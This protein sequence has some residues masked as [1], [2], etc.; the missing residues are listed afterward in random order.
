[1]TLDDDERRRR[2]TRARARR[3]APSACRAWPT[4]SSTCARARRRPP[5]SPTAACCRPTQHA[6]RRR[7]RRAAQ[8]RSTRRC[9]ADIQG[10]RARRRGRARRR[11]PRGRPTRGCECLNPAV[12]Q[13]TALG[14][15]ADARRGRAA[16]AAARTRRRCPACWRATATR[17]AA[18]IDATAGVLE[19]GRVRAR[20]ARPTRSSGAP[21]A[22]RDD[23]RARC[24][25]C[26]RGRCPRSTRCCATRARRSQPL[27]RAAARGRARRST[28][29]SRCSTA[30]A[31]LLPA[32]ARARSAPLPA[33]ERRGRAR[34]RL[35]HQGARATRCRC[36]S[37][38]A[39]LHARARRRASSTASAARRRHSYDAN[40]HYARDQP[41]RRADAACPGLLPA[42]A[43]GRLGG[44]P[45]RPR[46]A[47]PGRRRGAR[48]RRLEPVGRR[49]DR[50]PDLRP[51][52]QPPMSAPARH[53]PWRA[54]A[55]GRRGAS[56]R[57]PRRRRRATTSYRVDVVFDDSRGL[58][59]G[60]LVQVAGARVGDDRG[61]LGHARL[62]GAGPHARRPALRAVPRRRDAARSSRRA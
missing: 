17:S 53:R 10:D 43:G 12:S 47:L 49:R 31:R 18:G 30:C 46:R 26:A 62:Q 59:P 2:C 50:R 11:R 60:Q 33:L 1:M 44:L 24:G 35:D 27:G 42:P 39:A 16:L 58:I 21:A 40:G 25:A 5:R 15:R 3:S 56:P 52:G 9:A 29:R 51:E 13:L 36:S 61:R 28:T 41:R 6:R 54:V 55:R 57:S 48:A 7:P 37:R 34:D 45:H 38:P 14:P 20:G 32:G 8:R 23:R 22:L 4:A 19:R